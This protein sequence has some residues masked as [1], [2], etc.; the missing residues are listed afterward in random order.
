[1]A[2]VIRDH[3]A[4]LVEGQSPFA[5]APIADALER[6]LH[7]SL[8]AQAAIADALYDLQGKLLGVPV[9]ML[10]GGRCREAV[11]AGGLLYIK[12]S[13][14]ETHRR[15]AT[16]FRSGVSSFTLKVGVDPDADIRNVKAL[17]DRFADTIVLRVDAN[18]GMDFD[19]AL[20]LLKNLEPYD[21]DAAEQLL[22]IWDLDGMAELARR[23][24]IPMMTDECVATRSRP[25]R[26]HQA[27]RGERRTDQDSEEWRHS[28]LSEAVGDCQC[29]RHAHIS[30]QPSGTSIAIMACAHLAAAWPGSILEGPFAC[31]V[32][33]LA[34]DVV[35]EP[36][37]LAGNRVRV[38][39]T[40]GLGVTLD[41]D[42][43]R[44]LRVD[45]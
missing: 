25:H 9:H 32:D 40:P 18:A 45:L 44:A 10:L 8:Y 11:P 4:P 17:R 43:V 36:V 5:V 37:Q 6:A 2:T 12:P 39:D 42:R 30:G 31:G 29:G 28:P 23:F 33:V 26:S 38:P 7:H 34:E 35:T 22:P 27:A 3:F 20:R 21:I 16:F 14:R 24:A 19:S 41:E 1:M 15:R 13:L